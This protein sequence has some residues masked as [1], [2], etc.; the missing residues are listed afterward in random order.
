MEISLK[1]FPVKDLEAGRAAI[2]SIREGTPFNTV[3]SSYCT[4]KQ[5]ADG[6]Y[7]LGYLRKDQLAILSPDLYSSVV[8]AANA[9]VLPQPVEINGQFMV[10][11]VD[12][13]RLVAMPTYEQIK[14]SIRQRIASERVLKV[15][16]S[17]IND[18]GVKAFGFSGELL[19][20]SEGE[21]SRTLGNS[22]AGM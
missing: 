10:I 20:L 12:N 9:T 19:D 21:V 6:Q 3:L 14:S 16:L 13:K 8:T 18:F 4:N 7:D 17:K 22:A 15:T 5:F 1:M 11:R 2:K